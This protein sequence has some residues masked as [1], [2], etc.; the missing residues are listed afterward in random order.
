MQAGGFTGSIFSS[1]MLNTTSISSLWFIS[2]SVILLSTAVFG[3]AAVGTAKVKL[4]I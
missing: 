2:F 3:L 1:V 4:R